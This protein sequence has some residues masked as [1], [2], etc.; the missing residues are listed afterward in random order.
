MFVVANQRQIMNN[1][2]WD[3]FEVTK[4]WI[5]AGFCSVFGIVCVYQWWSTDKEEVWD[6]V[7][8]F[9]TSQD[10]ISISHKHLKK[11]MFVVAN[12][13]QIMNNMFWDMFEV[14]KGV[15]RSCNIEEGFIIQLGWTQTKRRYGISFIGL[16]RHIDL[17]NDLMLKAFAR[18]VD[19]SGMVEYHNFNCFSLHLK[20]FQKRYKNL[21]RFISTKTK[22][23][24]ISQM[25]TI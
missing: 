2:F 16:T 22:E 23:H 6:F 19:T 15:I 17:S 21:H 14:T 8:R 10:S 4:G 11:V 18:F 3:M 5:C 9:N 24:T 12:Q 20:L 7:Y 13:R 25:S 1:M